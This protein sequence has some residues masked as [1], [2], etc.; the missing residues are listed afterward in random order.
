MLK[1]IIE[2]TVKVHT[3][4]E[5]Q[6]GRIYSGSMRDRKEVKEKSSNILKVAYS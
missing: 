6:E 1:E 5:D 2:N 3:G 4:N